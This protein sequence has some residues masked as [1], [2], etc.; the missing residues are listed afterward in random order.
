MPHR[1]LPSQAGQR[2]RVGSRVAP[3]ASWRSEEG[4]WAYCEAAAAL[5]SCSAC[6]RALC[7]LIGS[8]A[9]ARW[10]I[11]MEGRTP[12]QSAVCV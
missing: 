8:F 4:C 5:S 9:L 6:M 1:G 2:Q 3:P 11:A 12:L 7:A 10:C